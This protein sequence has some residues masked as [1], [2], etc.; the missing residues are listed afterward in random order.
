MDDDVYLYAKLTIFGPNAK[1]HPTL[2][3]K[4]NTNW[5]ERNDE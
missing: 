2:M 5:H 1:K 4:K 3:K